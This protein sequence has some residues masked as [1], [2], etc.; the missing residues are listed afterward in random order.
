MILFLIF[1][2]IL[3]NRVNKTG[4]LYEKVRYKLRRIKSKQFRNSMAAIIAEDDQKQID[5]LV[6]YFESCVLPGCKA[7]LLEK[8]EISSGLRLKSNGTNRELFAKSFH[9]YRVDSDLVRTLHL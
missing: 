3:Y 7:E 4:L 2:C 1:Q 9:L 8:L 6:K 5:E